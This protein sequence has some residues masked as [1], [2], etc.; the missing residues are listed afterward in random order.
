MDGIA[1]VGGLDDYDT[2]VN[3]SVNQLNNIEEHLI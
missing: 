3:I 1:C 2:P